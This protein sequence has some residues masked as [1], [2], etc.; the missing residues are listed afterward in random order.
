MTVRILG[1]SARRVAAARGARSQTQAQA[2]RARED[3]LGFGAEMLALADKARA[4][5]EQD[6]KVSRAAVPAARASL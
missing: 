3:W 4:Q 1:A 5:A 6:A 2:L